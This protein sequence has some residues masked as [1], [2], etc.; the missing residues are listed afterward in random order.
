MFQYSVVNSIG[1]YSSHI[2]SEK[3][4]TYD[5]KVLQCKCELVSG[6]SDCFQL[7]Q[8]GQ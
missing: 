7:S 4:P 6:F 5:P 3:D 2:M 8:S 1:T